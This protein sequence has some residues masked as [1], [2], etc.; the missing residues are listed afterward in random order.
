MKT[1]SVALIVPAVIGAA[2]VLPASSASADSRTWTCE[3]SGHYLTN[4]VYYTTTTTD[5][6]WHYITYKLT[7]EGT[8][9]K[10][11]WSASFDD[12]SGVRNFYAN[13]AND[14]DQNTLYKEDFG[15]FSSLRSRTE[16][17]RASAA[18]D[19]RLT[20]NHCSSSTV[21]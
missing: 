18:F 10:S 8:G 14:L 1:R 7:G 4:T 13:N 12:G 16:T 15:D 21:W 17:W 9:G 11:N 20:D 6:Q 19:T 2:M 3:D 5:H